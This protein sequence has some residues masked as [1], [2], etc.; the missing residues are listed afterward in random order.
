MTG[1]HVKEGGLFFNG[2]VINTSRVSINNNMIYLC[3]I[4]ELAGIGQEKGRVSFESTGP[5]KS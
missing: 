3:I 1:G 2:I 4:N 5:R